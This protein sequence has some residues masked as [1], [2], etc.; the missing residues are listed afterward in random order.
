MAFRILALLMVILMGVSASAAQEPVLRVAYVDA[1]DLWLW[2]RGDVE[3][4]RLAQ[5]QIVQVFAAA[6]GAYLAFT[7]WVTQP[8]QAEA[9]SW[10]GVEEGTEELVSLPDVAAETRIVDVTWAGEQLFFSTAADSALGLMPRYDLWR[11]AAGDDAA[12]QLLEADTGG[13]ATVSPDGRWLAVVYPGV[14][15]G[16]AGRITLFNIADGALREMLRFP[17]VSTGANYAFLPLIQWEMDSAAFRVALPDKDLLYATGELPATVLWRSPINGDAIEV[18]R[19]Q[20][21]LFGLPRWSVA[22]EWITYLRPVGAAATNQFELVLAAG[23]GSDAVVYAEGQAGLLGLPHWLPGSTQFV[24]EQGA[25]GQYWLGEAGTDPQALPGGRFS[26]RWVDATTY[27]Y[28]SAP[29]GVFDL[30]V[31][32]IGDEESLLIDAVEHPVPV[33]AAWF[34]GGG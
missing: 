34:A 28:A 25:A 2:Q 17:A 23:D 18:G 24:Y 27:L 32:R 12:E 29:G 30:R 9:L 7:R 21:S 15:G 5:G 20:A 8:G 16:E 4:R 26:P 31:G 13:Q 14:Y 22:A 6:D 11:Y 19:V 10:L 33:F 1:G 3:P